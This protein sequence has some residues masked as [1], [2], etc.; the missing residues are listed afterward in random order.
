MDA[1]AQG[2]PYLLS[3]PDHFIFLQVKYLHA[4]GIVLADAAVSQVRGKKHRRWYISSDDIFYIVQPNII[5]APH[6]GSFNRPY[7]AIMP[8]LHLAIPVSFVRLVHP[9]DVGAAATPLTAVAPFGY[10]PQQ[11]CKQ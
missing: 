4:W 9:H 11:A 10:H 1:P 7:Y 2:H 8:L 6:T 5:F 3:L